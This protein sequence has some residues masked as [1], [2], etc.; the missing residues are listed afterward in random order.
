MKMVKSLL[1]GSA[2]GLVAVAGAQAADLPV[3]A[4]PVQYVKICSLYGVGFYYIPGTDMCVKIGGWVRSEYSYGGNG[5]FAWGWANGNV[6]NRTTNNSVFR[7]RGYITADARNQTEYGTVRA[8]LA[9]GVSEN[10]TGANTSSNTFSANRAFI[11]WAGFTFGRAQSFYDFYSSPATS[12]WGAFPSSDSGDP[13]WLVWGYT[14]QFGNGLSATISAE[15]RRMTQIIGPGVG[16]TAI[17]GTGFPG[18]GYGGLQSP[19]IVANLRIDQAWGSAQIMGALHQVNAT[20]YG[21]STAVASGHPGD[22]WGF[23]VGAGIKLNAPM[24]GKGD[25]L[26]AQVNYTQGAL[27]Y[28]F[29]TPNGNWGKVDGQGVGFGI[30]SDAVFGTTGS[31]LNLTTAW[32]VNAAYEHFWNARWKTSLY[33]GYA[34]V[35]Y[36]DTANALMC[37]ALAG[38]N[39]NWKSW[40]IGSRTQWNV[41]RD[42]YLGVDVMYSKLQSATLPAGLVPTGAVG[43]TSVKD[44]DNWGVRLRAHKDFYP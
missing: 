9:V 35:N 6:N 25:Y 18:G 20:Y 30:L 3:K 7:A 41:T 33:G 27:R 5:N 22:K 31:D 4:K 24:I 23:A 26:Q 10:D 12:Y 42:F 38:C 36:G 2:A 13:G 40:W 16:S 39:M 1:L 17:G 28:A 43:A 8:Y 21:G 15:E 14:A 11:Q 34:A 44:V 37:G 19:D 32:N 29:M